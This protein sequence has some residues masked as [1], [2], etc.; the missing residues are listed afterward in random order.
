MTD[1]R[2]R[3][4]LI[5]AVMNRSDDLVAV[6]GYRDEWG[7]V[8]ERTVSPIRF[9]DQGRFLALCLCRQEPRTLYLGRCLTIRVAPASE[10]MAPVK[11]KAA[12]PG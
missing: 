2:N 10:I 11:M 4:G 3:R 12:E 6:I 9:L 5:E 1:P 7:R 8:T